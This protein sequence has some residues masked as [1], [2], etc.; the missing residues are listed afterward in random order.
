MQARL[1]TPAAGPA[2]AEEAALG[3]FVA[4][5]I[6]TGDRLVGLLALG[7][8]HVAGHVPDAFL[9]QVASQAHIVM[10]NS[11]LFE[12]V[13][14]LAIRDSL[15]DVFNHRHAVDLI[16]QEVLRVARYREG[17]LSVLMLDIDH[18]KNIN[19]ELGHLAGDAVLREVARLLREGLRSVDS[20]GRYG[21]EEFVLILPQTR[22][23]EARQTAERLRHLIEQHPFRTGDQ[24]TRITVS[25]GVATFP[26]E[27]ID[28]AASLLREADEALYRAKELGRNRVM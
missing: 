20:V 6:A 21:G 22:H 2:G 27:H 26:S 11:P 23:E 5:P 12:R 7:G 1:F 3:G 18:F 4:V 25:L 16:Q 13:Q 19:D 10:Q 28:S 14:Q 8:R 9:Q 24:L 15:T 17:D